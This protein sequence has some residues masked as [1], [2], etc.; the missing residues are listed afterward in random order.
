M[1]TILVSMALMGQVDDFKPLPES[2]VYIY[3]YSAQQK[4]NEDMTG[5]AMEERNRFYKN[6]AANRVNV[7]KSDLSLVCL[8]IREDLRKTEKLIKT[9]STPRNT[10]SIGRVHFKYACDA[11]DVLEK[12]SPGK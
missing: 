3:R 5:K 2:R 11:L 6:V 12:Q 7:D 8:M 1:I 9:P 10:K 4:S